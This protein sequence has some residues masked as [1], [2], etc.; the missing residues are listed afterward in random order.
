MQVEDGGALGRIRRD[1]GLRDLGVAALAAALGIAM[2]VSLQFGLRCFDS[3]FII[4]T[5]WGI[6]AILMYGLLTWT[7]RHDPVLR[8][9]RPVGVTLGWTLAWLL[10]S[11]GAFVALGTSIFSPILYVVVTAIIWGIPMWLSMLLTEWVVRGL[12]RLH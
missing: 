3:T 1:L 4:L 11:S 7:R 2:A 5:T 9:A 10:S 6:P 12:L 8:V